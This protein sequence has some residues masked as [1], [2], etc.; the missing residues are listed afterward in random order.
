MEEAA[1]NVSAVRSD[2]SWE[3]PPPWMFGSREQCEAYYLPAATSFVDGKWVSVLHCFY[4]TWA[5]KR[6]ESL[7][8][9]LTISRKTNKKKKE[10]RLRLQ[11]T[12]LSKVQ[13]KRHHTKMLV[14]LL[15]LIHH[16]MFSVNHYPTSHHL[17]PGYS[18]KRR[19]LTKN[20][21]TNLEKV[22]PSNVINS[23]SESIKFK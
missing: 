13:G 11:E 5:S 1:N 22:N 23:K 6:P 12:Y 17:K 19:R 3:P 8:Q 15:A 20:Y 4:L 10:Y 2:Y 16:L 18:Y 21:K 9:P 14:G 7:G